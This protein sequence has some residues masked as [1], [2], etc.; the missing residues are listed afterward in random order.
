MGFS[1]S[2]GTG[3]LWLTT[4]L[5]LSPLGTKAVLG[6]GCCPH[7]HGTE[8]RARQMQSRDLSLVWDFSHSP[9]PQPSREEVTALL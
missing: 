7:S 2:Q 6:K 9:F 8:E 3:E 1:L 4:A 5:A